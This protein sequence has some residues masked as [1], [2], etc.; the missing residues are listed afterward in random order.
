M[1]ELQEP[2]QGEDHHEHCFLYDQSHLKGQFV[3]FFKWHLIGNFRS[4]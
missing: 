3:V 4:G 1:L 2:E